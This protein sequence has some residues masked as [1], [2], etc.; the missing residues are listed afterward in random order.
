MFRSILDEPPARVR[1]EIEIECSQF[2]P[3]RRWCFGLECYVLDVTVEFP[4]DW[5]DL[6]DDRLLELLADERNDIQVVEEA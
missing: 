2:T 6:T 5:A 1:R 3:G 4:V